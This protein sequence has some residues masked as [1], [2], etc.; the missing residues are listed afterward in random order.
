MEEFIN[1]LPREALD[2]IADQL[3]IIHD[4]MEKDIVLNHIFSDIDEAKSI[5]HKYCNIDIDT[6]Y[7]NTVNDEYLY[8]IR[9]LVNHSFDIEDKDGDILLEAAESNDV[10]ILTFL[11]ENDINLV[12]D[13]FLDALEQASYNGSY[14]AVQYL[15]GIIE[16]DS[17]DI[18]N[19]SL[20][21]AIKGKHIK[22][23][24]FFISAGVDINT[25]D[26][27]ILGASLTTNNLKF[28]KYLVSEG[29]VYKKKHMKLIISNDIRKYLEDI[30][31][32]KNPYKTVRDLVSD[33][34]YYYK[35]QKLCSTLD[36]KNLEELKS[37]ATIMGVKEFKNKRDLCKSLSQIYDV[38]MNKQLSCV[39][40]TSILGDPVNLIPKPLL[41][42]I[43][44]VAKNSKGSDIVQSYCFNIM[45]LV[46]LIKGGDTRNPFTRNTLPVEYIMGKYDR[47][48]S[49]LVKDK[50][51]IVNILDEIRNNDI[52]TKDSIHNLV[53]INIFSKLKY[54][55]P[56]EMFKSIP[57]TVLKSLYTEINSNPLFTLK[58]KILNKY[59]LVDEISRNL[60]I[61]DNNSSTRI[62]AL[63]IYLNEL[64]K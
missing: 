23:A 63:E 11:A 8:I 19:H 22:I 46:E 15:V 4:V 12:S 3:G 7:R 6:L 48:K 57:D 62:A 16:G 9:Y 64:V 39:N 14:E 2:Q 42:T 31:E 30:I 5:L 20:Y 1:N 56:I 55:P 36:N 58:I 49:I 43:K 24:N 26:P 60:N 27:D 21:L 51:A 41:V 35:W 34:G 33:K 28:V 47:L 32:G 10:V 53:L 37:L 61:D 18:L 29:A 54:P 25:E 17:I 52:M 59:T 40:D 13:N 50:L 44:E 45:E 38:K